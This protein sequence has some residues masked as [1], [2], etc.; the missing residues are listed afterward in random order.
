VDSNR[1]NPNGSGLG[2]FIIKQIIEKHHGKIE[3]ASEGEGKGTTFTVT[4]PIVQP[5]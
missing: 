3:F 4:L 5:R 1:I 2:L